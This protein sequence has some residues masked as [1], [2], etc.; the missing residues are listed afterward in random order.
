MES[1]SE[2]S[3]PLDGLCP[4]RK[5]LSSSPEFGNEDSGQLLSND[6]L[7]HAQAAGSSSLWS[8][9]IAS[10]SMELLASEQA[11]ARRW[12]PSLFSLRPVSRG[13]WKEG[14][15]PLCLDHL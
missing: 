13:W 14:A 8:S 9:G 1:V 7:L 6:T 3:V 10:P 2:L 11:G 5:N 15:P 12:G 4:W